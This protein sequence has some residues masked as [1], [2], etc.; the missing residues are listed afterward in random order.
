MTWDDRTN[1]KT[2]RHLLWGSAGQDKA[3][4][5]PS[6]PLDQKHLLVVLVVVEATGNTVSPVSQWVNDVF[7]GVPVVP[8]LSPPYLLIFRGYLHYLHG[9]WAEWANV[10]RVIC[11]RVEPMQWTLS[12]PGP[13]SYC[14]QLTPSSLH[15][16]I[17]SSVVGTARTSSHLLSPFL[18]SSILSHWSIQQI[19]RSEVI[20]RK[21]PL[22]SL[23]V[24]I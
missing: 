4:L 16:S 1:C 21:L 17:S 8:G 12:A 18:I 11:H 15:L 24:S 9:L 7:P 23:T 22:H 10:G 13:S 19:P 6:P 14:P 2:R 3:F 20:S 5:D